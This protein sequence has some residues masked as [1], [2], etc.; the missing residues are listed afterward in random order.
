MILIVLLIFMLNMPEKEVL[1]FIILSLQ[2]R[3]QRLDM[4]SSLPV[5]MIHV[6]KTFVM[7]VVHGV[8]GVVVKPI[9]GKGDFLFMLL[10]D[11]A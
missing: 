2:K 8:S 10:F 3:L 11:S 6:G 9:M 4:Q 1:S 7:G 5:T